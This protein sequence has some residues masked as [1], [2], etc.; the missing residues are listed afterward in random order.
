MLSPVGD[1]ILQNEITGWSMTV[2]TDFNE[3]LI[4]K[5]EFTK[6]RRGMDPLPFFNTEPRRRLS[7]V[8]AACRRSVR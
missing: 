8:A 4:D 7:A 3:H 5:F 2:P 1:V 6:S